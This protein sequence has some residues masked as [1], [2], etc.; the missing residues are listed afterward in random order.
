MVGLVEEGLRVRHQA[1]DPSC[2]IADPRDSIYGAVGI[3]GIVQRRLTVIL[4]TVLNGDQA[5][6]VEALQ[7]PLVLGDRISPHRGGRVD[8]DPGAPG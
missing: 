2:R 6:P 1:E 7:N 5:L 8:K 3:G 4:I